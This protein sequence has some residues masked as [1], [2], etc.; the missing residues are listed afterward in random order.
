MNWTESEL[1]KVTLLACEFMTAMK[2][3]V[4]D[5]VHPQLIIRALR[6]SSQ[7]AVKRIKVCNFIRLRVIRIEFEGVLRARVDQE[8]LVDTK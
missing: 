6:T 4:E 7:M 2:R 5:G 1:L 3:F 8:E